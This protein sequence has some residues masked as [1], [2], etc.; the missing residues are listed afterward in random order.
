[1]DKFDRRHRVLALFSLAIT[2][3][4][5][6]VRTSMPLIDGGVTYRGVDAYYHLRNVRYSVEHWP[7]TLAFDPYTNFPYGNSAGQFGTGY[8]LAVATIAKFTPLS[9]E[10]A[11]F[12]APVAL[13]V[14]TLLVVYRLARR[15]LDPTPA[16]LAAAVFAL[17]PGI[18][19]QRTLAGMSDHHAAETFLMAASVLAVVAMLQAHG[20]RAIGYA[21]LAGGV[22]AVYVWT[23]P[24]G[25]LLVAIYA[26][27]FWLSQSHHVIRDTSPRPVLPKT[28]FFGV[29]AAVLLPLAVPEFTVMTVSTLHVVG[30]LAA[31]CVL[32][33]SYW[34]RSTT[35]A[36]YELTSIAAATLGLG[37]FYVVAPGRLHGMLLRAR[38]FILFGSDG[39]IHET[40]GW[41]SAYS[42]SGLTPIHAVA[43]LYGASV[44]FAVVGAAYVYL[45]GRW[46]RDVAW[47]LGVW[48]V[49]LTSAS[50]TQLRFH[51]YLV[52]PVAVFAGAALQGG[53]DVLPS[54]RN[55]RHALVRV[56]LLVMLTLSVPLAQAGMQPQTD[57]LDDWRPAL[58]FL[59]EE[60][61]QPSVDY[62]GT[63]QRQAD[64]D[65]PRGSYGVLSWW[66]YG[67]WITV[68]GERPAVTNPHQQQAA[69]AAQYFLAT[70]ETQ[71]DRYLSRM[72][73]DDAKVR[74][75]VLDESMTDPDS[76]LASIAAYHP[77]LELSDV[78]RDG[79]YTRRYNASMLYTLRTGTADGWT[80]V[81]SQQGVTI[82]RRTVSENTTIDRA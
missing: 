2:M 13:A 19:L 36:L 1:M 34:L 71:A 60:T 66:D 59:N 35:P 14:A 69:V 15:L 16:L 40:L 77:D 49:V 44:L 57:G 22:T 17:Q 5:T 39:R 27:G 26:A 52:L 4:Y 68:M 42:Q 38:R 33:V 51:Y 54:S 80:T 64:F 8:D 70:N 31:A 53:F 3:V 61:V 73:E 6:R 9:A 62:H 56:V 37:A 32:A 41:A 78:Y 65:Y 30:A 25:L 47:V 45:R 28:V 12:Y 18:Y 76:R 50:I 48:A 74:Y 46:S 43:F 29:L 72:E 7:R 24:P 67:H 20:R 23:W 10:L 82:L 55:G 63:Y 11:L 79:H 75:I 81:Y 21:V 58:E